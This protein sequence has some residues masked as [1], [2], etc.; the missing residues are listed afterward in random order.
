M[1]LT[2][3]AARPIYCNSRDHWPVIEVMCTETTRGWRGLSENDRTDAVASLFH[4]P[5][6]P[7]VSGDPAEESTWLIEEPLVEDP[8]LSLKL[9]GTLRLAAY[10]FLQGSPDLTAHEFHVT[11]IS[12]SRLVLTISRE[13]VFAVD[14]NGRGCET[15]S[16]RLFSRM[17]SPS[18]VAAHLIEAQQQLS[19]RRDKNVH[20]RVM[21]DLDAVASE[22]HL[23]LTRAFAHYGEAYGDTGTAST[24]RQAQGGSHG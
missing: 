11:P 4:L 20:T 16:E 19:A 14:E 3:T 13:I 9:N 23:A 8:A 1:Q 12:A 22:G 24:R 6:A 18:S 17:E 2:P 7:M 21:P 15:T 10:D 5:K